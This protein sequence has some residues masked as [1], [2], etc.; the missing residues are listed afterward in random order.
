MVAPVHSALALDN[1]GRDVGRLPLASGNHHWQ[2]S[3]TLNQLLGHARPSRVAGEAIVQALCLGRR[4][5]LCG[6]SGSGR[7]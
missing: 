5:A 4:S 2:F 7:G 6:R 1:T 3:V